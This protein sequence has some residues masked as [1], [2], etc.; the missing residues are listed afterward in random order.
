MVLSTTS[1]GRRPSCWR[2]SHFFFVHSFTLMRIFSHI[3]DD[4]AFMQQM[5]ISLFYLC[6]ILPV[7]SIS[8]VWSP[9]VTS[10]KSSTFSMAGLANMV[11]S[12][13]VSGNS[14][15]RKTSRH[16]GCVQLLDDTNSLEKNTCRFGTN[17]I[18]KL[19]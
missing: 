7:E 10:G 18:H 2:L 3:F 16:R 15:V 8:T 4:Y 11:E 1:L 6:D 12:L 13:S 14:R 19:S 17:M 9:S 5:M